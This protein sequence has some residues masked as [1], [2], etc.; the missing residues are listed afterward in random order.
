M[1]SYS[2]DGTTYTQIAEVVDIDAPEWAY[3]TQN[4]PALANLVKKSRTTLPDGGE[5]GATIY[6]DTQEPTHAF[7]VSLMAAPG[8]STG[9]VETYWKITLKDA[10]TPGYLTFTGFLT[11]LKLNGIEEEGN[12]TADIKIKLNSTITI[13]PGVG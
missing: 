5:L 1:L 3:G 13:T 10:P 11:G 8:T 12:L 9:G 7:L 2:T 4:L 6:Y